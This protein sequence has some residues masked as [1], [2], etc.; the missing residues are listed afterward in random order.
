[1]KPFGSIFNAFP[2]ITLTTADDVKITVKNNFYTKVAFKL[3][4]MPHVGIRLRGKKILTNL[5][6]KINRMLDAGC[7]TGIYS[8][9]L[10]KKAKKI[11]AV[12]IAKDKVDYVRN[13]NIF[14]NI[15]FDLGDLTKLK[16]KDDGFDLIIC[17][18]V[19]EHIKEHEKAFS[20]LSRVLAKGGTLLITVPYNSRKNKI[21]F[22]KYG[23]ER[24]G[25]NNEIM[26][27]L[28]R[29]NGLKLIKSE[30]YSRDASEKFSNITDEKLVYNK[31][32]LGLVF[33][34]YTGFL[35]FVIK[36]L[37]IPSRM[38]YFLRL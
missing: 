1:M 22:K 5:P 19:L 33:I 30:G 37:E 9:T 16:F 4:G 25:Y 2:Y 12:D 8:F 7:G 26:Q 36:Y 17:S 35:C 14:K 3:L 6:E 15:N 27:K 20:E 34:P 13:V 29:K 24:P 10:A 21:I 28:C 31:P 32:V 11:E 38:E 23:H 18:D